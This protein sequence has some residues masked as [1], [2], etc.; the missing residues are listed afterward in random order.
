MRAA[1]HQHP[2]ELYV[3]KHLEY[4]AV[5]VSHVTASTIYWTDLMLEMYLILD[6]KGSL[7]RDVMF[8]IFLFPHFTL[9]FL[10]LSRVSLSL[11]ITDK[12][13]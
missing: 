4:F 11:L 13:N 10:C 9:C 7:Y 8:H 3:R 6:V 5:L 2:L 12:I 1:E